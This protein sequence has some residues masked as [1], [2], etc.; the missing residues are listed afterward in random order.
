MA[1]SHPRV[2]ILA[3]G[4]GTRMKSHLPKVLHRAAGGALLGHVLAAASAARGAVGVVLGRSAAEVRRILPSGTRV[5]LQKRRLGSGHAAMTASAWLR[6]RPGPVV[7]LMGDAPLVRPE[8]VRA[9]LTLHRRERN[10][11]TLLTARVPD[12]RGYG[13]VVRGAD[14]R[15]RA[16]VEHKDALPWQRGIDEINS[17]AYCFGS[18]ELAG[19]L[20]RLRPDNAKGEYYLTDAVALLERDGRR[21]GA[22]RLEDPEEVLG[23]NTRKELAAAGRALRRRALERLMAAGVT[24]VDPDSTHVDPGVRV[25]RDAVIEPFTFLRGRTRVGRGAVVGPFCQVTDCRIGAGAVVRASFAQEA[26]VEAGA[27]VGPYAHLRPGT[28]VG[29][30]ARVGNF[31]ELKQATLGPGAKANHLAYV[32]DASVGAEANI[33]AGV[34]TCNYDGF[35]KHRTSIGRG[36]FVGSNANLIAPV[37]IGR[38]ALVGA[39]STVTR[40]VPAG[41]LALERSQQTVKRGWADRRRREQS[42]RAGRSRRP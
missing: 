19:A 20:A 27:R 22:L 23:V 12:P 25:G 10:A 24:V 5:F 29:R 32:G 9:L 38:G 14:G 8:T 21:V 41:A 37:R 34:I 11:V 31:V 17:G 28:R 1:R 16:I 3:A 40:D 15:P 33:G 4:E 18:T 36:A 6:G 30:N 7:L 26:V 39:G 13:R 42:R 2:L 35:R